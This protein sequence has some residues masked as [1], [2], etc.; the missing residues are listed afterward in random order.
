MSAAHTRGATRIRGILRFSSGCHCK[1]NEVPR[2]AQVRYLDGSVS[3]DRS[4]PISAAPTMRMSSGSTASP[5]RAASA[6]SWSSNYRPQAA[7]EDARGDGL[8]GTRTRPIEP[9]QGTACRKEIFQI[10]KKTFEGITELPT[11]STEVHFKQRGRYHRRG[12]YRVPAA[13]RQA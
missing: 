9:A 10:F 12:S 4:R 11:R 5:E 1:G 8:C 3:A 2:G 13:A 7:A 6:I